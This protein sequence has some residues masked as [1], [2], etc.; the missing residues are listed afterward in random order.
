MCHNQMCELFKEKISSY[1]ILSNT[2]LLMDIDKK[3]EENNNKNN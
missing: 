2:N 1:K 3:K